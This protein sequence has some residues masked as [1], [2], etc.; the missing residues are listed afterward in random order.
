MRLVRVESAQGPVHGVIIDRAVYVVQGD[1]F[2]SWQVGARMCTLEEARLLAPCTPSKI[3]A[4][5]RNYLDHAREQ[6]T[7][8]P[9]EPI[10]FLKAPTAV[11]GH[12][13]AVVYPSIS[14]RVDH[15]G[16]LAVVIGRRCREVDAAQARQ[17]ILGYT[18]ANDITARDIQ[19][20]DGQWARGK[21]FDTFLPLGPCIATSLDLAHATLQTRV[22]GQVRQNASLSQLLF[23]VDYLVSFI[24]QVMTL[25]PGDVVLT[26]TPA[27]VG[28]LE[29]GDVVEVEI[30]G[31]GTLRN[32]VVAARRP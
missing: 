19:R 26:G 9:A 21:S 10:L 15:E 29:P 32:H 17:Y 1:V 24:S 30:S 7:D 5:G 4:V 31:I 16:E 25:V 2:G 20:R 11:I 22:N 14:Q 3:A 6:S 28:P 27:G 13:D 23:G 12:L 8:P 18:C